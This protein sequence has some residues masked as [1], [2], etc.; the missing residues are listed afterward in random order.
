[1]NKPIKIASILAITLALVSWSIANKGTENTEE[2]SSTSKTMTKKNEEIVNVA[3]V[4]LKDGKQAQFEQYKTKGAAL[5]EKYGGKIERILKP[6]MVVRGDIELPDEIHFATYPSMEVFNAFNADPEFA[7]LRETLA[8]P[9]IEK[10]SVFPSKNTDFKFEKE[11]GDFKKTFGVA[12]VYFKEGVQ[13]QRQF[14]EYHNDACAILPEF[15]AHFERFVAPF[16]Q[17]GDLAQP[18]EIHRFYFDSADGMQQMGSDQRMQKLF[19]KRD[20]SLENLI[21]ILGEA[22]L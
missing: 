19:P 13:Y 12:L 20:A 8:M 16:T 10:I 3:F 9:S 17:M 15:G 21:F 1:M 6:K 2:I 7:K 18:D 14:A 5:L 11:H 22:I 4:Y